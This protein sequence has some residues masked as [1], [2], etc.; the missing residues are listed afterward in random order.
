MVRLWSRNSVGECSAVA[1][2]SVSNEGEGERSRAR[3]AAASVDQHSPTAAGSEESA[4]WQSSEPEFKQQGGKE[5][6]SQT[7]KEDLGAPR[8]LLK[9]SVETRERGEDEIRQREAQQLD[10]RSLLGRRS[11]PSNNNNSSSISSNNDF[12]TGQEDTMDFK[13]NLKG[14][15]SKF[16][17]DRKSNS[18]QQVDFRAVLGKKGSAASPPS[19]AGNKPGDNKNATDFRSV[20]ANKKKAPEKN[21]ETPEKPAEKEKEKAAVNNCVDGAHH[22]KKAAAAGAGGGGG[23][24][25]GKGPEFKEKLSD[26]T[27]V[28]GQRLRLQCRLAD[29]AGATVTWTLDGKV[30]KASKF[31]VLANEG[32]LCSLSIDKALPEDEGQYKCV[33]ENA[34][35]RSECSCMV[36][37]VDPAENSPADKKSKK[38]TPTSESE[39]PKYAAADSFLLSQ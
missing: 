38:A 28:D 33:A 13:A 5:E 24:A 21:G 29:P 16:E 8:G 9:R 32:G 30:I 15:K 10:F 22:E 12:G 26:V 2:L 17:D 25:G 20:L 11:T 3:R 35:G 6:D 39:F 7:A 36:L 4:Q 18:T 1:C 23:A 27:A 34:T 19:N 31:I 37:V 14:L